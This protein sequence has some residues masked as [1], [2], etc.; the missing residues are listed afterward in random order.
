MSRLKLTPK[1]RD[2]VS[3]PLR[4]YFIQYVKKLAYLALRLTEFW[5]GLPQCM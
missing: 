5:L 1:F 3:D 2:S 4:S